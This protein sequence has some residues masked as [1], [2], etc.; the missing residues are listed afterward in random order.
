[1]H[2]K[3]LEYDESIAVMLGSRIVVIDE[4]ILKLKGIYI[5]SH[6]LLLHVRER[7]EDKRAHR[8]AH[9]ERRQ[10]CHL[11]GQ[12]RQK[13]VIEGSRGGIEERGRGSRAAEIG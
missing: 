12:M 8:R 1:M 4:C 11:R 13:D 10:G 2:N 9:D 7:L 6:D 3:Y 5:S